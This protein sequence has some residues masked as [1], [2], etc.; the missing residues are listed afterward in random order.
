MCLLFHFRFHNQVPP[1]GAGTV[2]PL[3]PWRQV[4]ALFS[5]S[6]SA[7]RH[8]VWGRDGGRDGPGRDEGMRHNLVAAA[9]GSGNQRNHM[10]ATCQW[11]RAPELT[12][13]GPRRGRGKGMAIQGHVHCV[14]ACSNKGRRGNTPRFPPACYQVAPVGV[15]RDFCCCWRFRRVMCSALHTTSQGGVC[16]TYT[17][18]FIPTGWQLRQ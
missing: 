13:T 14:T 16:S 4:V 10:P 2:S 15:C 3:T 18:C 1:V 7:P 6:V 9:T 12:N 8:W 17:L 11:Q 5:P